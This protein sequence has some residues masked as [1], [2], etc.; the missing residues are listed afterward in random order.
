[1]QERFVLEQMRPEDLP[2]I[3]D[4]SGVSGAVES[5]EMIPDAR[6]L[7][8]LLSLDVE[9][10]NSEEKSADEG[11]GA[12]SAREDGETGPQELWRDSQGKLQTAIQIQPGW[13]ETRDD[14]GAQGSAGPPTPPTS[15]MRRSV[16]KGERLAE[17]KLK[18]RR[19]WEG[20]RV[21]DQQP[22]KH[23]RLDQ[24]D[25]RQ[26]RSMELESRRATDQ[27]EDREVPG[28]QLGEHQRLDQ[29]KGR[30][31]RLGR[32]DDL[33]RAMELHVVE[34]LRRQ[35]EEL[36]NAEPPRSDSYT[37]D[38]NYG[39]VHTDGTTSAGEKNSRGHT[40]PSGDT[41][42]HIELPEVPPWPWAKFEHGC[43]AEEWSSWERRQCERQE[44]GREV[45]E[46][47]DREVLTAGYIPDGMNYVKVKDV[48]AL[49]L[50]LE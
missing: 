6:D 22:E 48:M 16:E 44:R 33:Q 36:R 35:N 37:K 10:E 12:I 18:E 27:Q 8:D 49:A 7:L 15:W 34:E 28:Q 25:G 9:P 38:T 30:Q 17:V 32:N 46:R 13:P 2:L 43:S 39:N 11:G 5:E 4:D 29:G 24:G 42:T 50:H 1:M 47:T 20:H 3:P 45:H 21:P 41:T 14:S 26:A 23:Q 19:P 40:S 31:D